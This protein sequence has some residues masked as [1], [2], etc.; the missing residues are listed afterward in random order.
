M[1]DGTPRV[2]LE[3]GRGHCTCAFSQRKKVID[4][5]EVPSA[6]ADTPRTLHEFPQTKPSPD[7]Q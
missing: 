3:G 4:S 5:L 6:Q 7:Q 1:E 2:S